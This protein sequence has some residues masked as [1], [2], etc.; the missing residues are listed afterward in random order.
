MSKF[1]AT[2]RAGVRRSAFL[3]NQLLRHGVV[4]ATGLGLW[5]HTLD[6]RTGGGRGLDTIAIK[7]SGLDGM[8]PSC[9]DLGDKPLTVLTKS[10]LNASAG[11][12]TDRCSWTV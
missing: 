6:Y 12:T 3:V 8:I 11:Q 1:C 5:K 7:D 2:G 10:K 9:S 4:V